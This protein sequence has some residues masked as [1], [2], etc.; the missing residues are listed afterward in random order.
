MTVRE[1][2]ILTRLG[3]LAGSGQTGVLRVSGDFGGAVYLREGAVIYARSKRTPG[4][5]ISSSSSF[6]ERSLA[7]REATIDAVLEM[8]SGVSRHQPRLRF[9]ASLAPGPGLADDLH[10][11]FL[12]AEV[13]R[14]R[15]IIKQLAALLTADSGVRRNSQLATVVRI[16]ARQWS[17]LIRVGSRST[18]RE[19]AADLGWSVFAAT[20]EVAQLVGLRLLDLAD[21]LAPLPER[22]SG[23]A[24]GRLPAAV[25]SLRALTR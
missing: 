4:P 14:R 17:V 9:Y 12:A 3:K 22:A 24:P 6:L 2:A 16:S 20:I 25:C 5:V 15:Q 1:D 19:L 18:P 10:I 23:S 7:V 11:E 8:L 13:T 21:P